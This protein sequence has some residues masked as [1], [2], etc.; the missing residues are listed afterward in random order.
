MGTD[1]VES[2]PSP[3]SRLGLVGKVVS[4]VVTC[5][6][7]L[8]IGLYGGWLAGR[9][10]GAPAAGGH[11]GHDHGAEGHEGHAHAE[12]T[13]LSPQT[14]ANLG[15][16]FA[17]LTETNFIRSREVPA[18]VEARPD[19]V[20][21]ISAP[22]AGR[23]TRT[24]VTAGQLL[25]AGDP[26]AEIVRDPFPRPVLALTDSVLKPLNEDFHR[27]ITELRATSRSLEIVREEVERIR[28][29]LAVSTPGGAPAVLTKTEIDLGYEE[30]KVS[31]ALDSARSEVRRHGLTDEE[32]AAIESGTGVVPDVPPVRTILSRNRLWSAGAD[33]ALALLP[34]DVRDTP[35]ALAVLGELAGTGTLTGELVAALKAQ[36]ALA[37][38]FLDIA[39]LIQQGE[40]VAAL[41]SRIESGA[42]ASTVVVRA[43]ADAPT[44]DV[45]SLGVRSG[46]RVDLG[47]VIATIEDAR[48]V[49]VR[50]APAGGDVEW[51]EAALAD[52]GA[53]IAE[54]LVAGAGAPIGDIR[55]RRMDRD[56]DGG[57]A[58]SALA[59]VANRV[60][61][62]IGGEGGTVARTWALRPGMRYFVRVPVESL[63]KRFVLP[64]DALIP[65]GAD[66]VLVVKHG[67][68]YVEVPVHV[69]YSDS[70]VAVVANDGA[71]FAGDT[72]AHKGAYALSLALQAGKGGAVDPHAGHN[73]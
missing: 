55:L 1:S 73:H 69:E 21:P 35:Y 40:T 6:L 44:W 64:A 30:R 28:R 70:R 26:V 38:A 58:V 60:V 54:P 18:I 49:F 63:F 24:F 52:G 4:G 11:E 32:I 12:E 16:E 19:G 29:V 14:L 22:V 17:P 62:D 37:A 51:V 66:T 33:E 47:A 48:T 23:V 56:P 27:G 59:E 46:A 39:G 3:G 42:L 7:I 13:K 5:S 53:L 57:H 36:P 20:R 34:A 25:K 43:P 10:G 72:V 68:T 8:G 65:R 61:A 45:T 67:A 71:V 15:V 9:Q 31:R 2:A 50:L 41:T